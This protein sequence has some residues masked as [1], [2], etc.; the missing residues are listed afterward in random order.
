M[1]DDING[2]AR[3]VEGKVKEGVGELLGDKKMKREGKLAQH[4]GEAEQD[5]DRA[6]ERLNEATQRESAARAARK[7]SEST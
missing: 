5:A 3:H 2:K 6:R 7:R 1:A 4:E